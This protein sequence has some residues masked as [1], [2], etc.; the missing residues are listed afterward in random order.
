MEKT[1]QIFHS[2]KES[3][4]ADKRYHQSLTPGERMEILQ[5]LIT[6]GSQHEVEQGFQRV[7]RVVKLKES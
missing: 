3:E 7:Y 1:V 2:F 4:E 6:Q 5:E